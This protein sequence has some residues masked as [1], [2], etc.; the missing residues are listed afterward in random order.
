MSESENKL[1]ERINSKLG[2]LIALQMV[3]EKPGKLKDKIK[4]LHNLGIESAEIA[5]ILG[6]SIGFVA[7]EKSLL[8]KE[9]K[10]G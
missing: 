10:N 8:N 9:K 6:T 5:S 7:K 4:L 1:L 3:E 2:I